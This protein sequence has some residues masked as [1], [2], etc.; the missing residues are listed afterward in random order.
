MV[1]PA[2]SMFTAPVLASTVATLSSLEEL[3][4]AHFTDYSIFS[5]NF[6]NVELMI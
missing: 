5:T 2:L 3:T 1:V 6:A 4:P